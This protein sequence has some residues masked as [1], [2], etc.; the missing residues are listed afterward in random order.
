VT[1]VRTPADEFVPDGV[2]WL[3]ACL[4]GL[5]GEPKFAE[6][7]AAHIHYALIAQRHHLATGGRD[8][9]TGASVENRAGVIEELKALLRAAKTGN[10]QRLLDAWAHSGDRTRELVWPT[11]IARAAIKTGR[12]QAFL[13]GPAAPLFIINAPFA[14]DAIPMIEQALA[15]ARAKPAEERRRRQSD[16]GVEDVIKAIVEAYRALTGQ[17]A[18]LTYNAI[19]GK[20]GGRFLDL[21][22][23][24]GLHFSLPEVYSIS[25]LRRVTARRRSPLTNVH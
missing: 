22:R 16:A 3:A 4:A 12:A 7:Y 14:A 25:R 17:R 5:G 18:G 10:N 11:R 15:V 21:C 13:S 20:W 19:N 23:D 8:L 2:K 6:R 1:A 24:I 9:A